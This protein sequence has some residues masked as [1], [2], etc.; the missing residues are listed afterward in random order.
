MSTGDFVMPFGKH[1]GEPLSDIPT[2]YL[3]YVLGFDDL[4]PGTEAAIVAHLETR[5]DWNRQE[6]E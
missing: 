3:D 1:R 4:Y 6:S 5:P 2:D